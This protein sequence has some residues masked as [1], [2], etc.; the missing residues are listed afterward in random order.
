MASV[1]ADATKAAR[2]NAWAATTKSRRAGGPHP[3]QIARQH[4]ATQGKVALELPCTVR[5]FSEATGVGSGQ[6]IKSLMGM[7]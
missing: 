5:S 7:G 3:Q 4:R 6:V 1:R 2:F